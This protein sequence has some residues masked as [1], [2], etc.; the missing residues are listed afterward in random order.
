MSEPPSG[1]RSP[2]TGSDNVAL[3]ATMSTT[4]LVERWQ[5]R[6]Q[7]DINEE[8]EGIET[9][10]VYRCNDTG[11][12]FYRPVELAG[13]AKLYQA[14]QRR[15]RYYS[16]LKWE[17]HQ[18]LRDI[19]RASRLL[20]IGCADGAFVKSALEHGIEASG[21]DLNP[22]AVA[23][24][25]T[26][27]LQVELMDVASAARVHAERFDVVCCFQ[28]LEHQAEPG[29]FLR[30][31]VTLLKAGGILITSVPNE[32][33]FLKYYD[34]LLNLPPH[35]MSRWT[36]ATFEAVGRWFD[37]E[38]EACIPEPLAKDQVRSY[39]NSYGTYL[40]NRWATGP[41][42]FNGRSFG[43]AE[44]LL[45]LGLRR[46]ASGHTLYARFVKPR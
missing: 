3:V 20:E 43:V 12:V 1:V 42:V 27:D 16:G 15:S 35:H 41:L 44:R 5:Q 25:R 31:C 7:I 40:R 34:E 29:G 32:D 36:R 8:F 18:A 37:L 6:F 13:S 30:D 23:R 45:N 28:V 14:L 46:F 24:A 17:H 9:V 22:D 4:R 2:L 10:S 19:K 11:L 21:I 39:V 38:L 33:G 26:L